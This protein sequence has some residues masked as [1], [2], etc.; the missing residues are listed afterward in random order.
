MPSSP[1][2]VCPERVQDLRGDSAE[3]RR[4][5]QPPPSAKGAKVADGREYSAAGPCGL[6]VRRWGQ[7]RRRHRLR[8]LSH[9]RNPVPC[10]VFVF[11]CAGPP[12]GGLWWPGRTGRARDAASPIRDQHLAK[13]RFSRLGPSRRRERLECGRTA[14]VSGAMRGVDGRIFFSV[15]DLMRF[16]GRRHATRLGL[17]AAP[18]VKVLMARP[19][20]ASCCARGA[21]MRAIRPPRGAARMG[22]GQSRESSDR[23]NFAQGR[24]AAES[25][26]AG[27]V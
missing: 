13:R 19:A 24:F 15:S 6:A 4:A 8:F 2:I 17:L 22:I 21:A 23:R 3:P 10:G 9:L 16:T 14:S 7:G 12:C 26:G 1:S 11:R 5:C 18:G 25:S 27:W 20:V